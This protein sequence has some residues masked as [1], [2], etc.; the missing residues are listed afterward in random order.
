MNPTHPNFDLPLPRR[1]WWPWNEGAGWVGFCQTFNNHHSVSAQ[2]YISASGYYRA[3]LDHDEIKPAA[4]SMPSWRSMHNMQVFLT[5][6][7]HLLR[8][9]AHTGGNSQPFLMVCL[10]WEEN[11]QHFRVASGPQW[12][13]TREPG[14]GWH[15]GQD[16]NNW[17][18]AWA[19]DGPWAEPWGMPCNAP[20]DFCRLS[21]GWQQVEDQRLTCVAGLFSGLTTAGGAARLLVGGAIALRPSWPHAL[22]IPA[23]EHTRPRLEW[24]RTRE[25]HS[26]ILNTWL[27]LFEPRAPHVVFDCGQETFARLRV[28]VRSGG[29]TILAITT[30]ESLNEVHRYA[31][32][33]TDIFELKDGQSYT[34]APTGFR[35][36]KI[37]A[38]SAAKTGDEVMIEP[39]TAEHIRYPLTRRGSFQ[40]SDSLLNKVWDL[41][42]L[43]TH[44]CMQNE[45]WDGIK[46]DQLPWM[47]DLYTEALAIYT[48]FGDYQLTRHTLSVLAEIGP[49]EARPLE[50]QLYP[51]LAAI[52]KSGMSS[53]PGADSGDING[54][55]SYTLWWI[56]GLADYV[57]FSGDKSLIQQIGDELEQTL[58]H[59]HS[60]IGLNHV[61]QFHGGWDFID[62]AP[63][64]QEERA[65]YCH[66]LA[67][68]AL[69]KGA[70]LLEMIGKPF[71]EFQRTYE[72]MEQATRSLWP[73]ARGFGLSHHVN[74]MVIRSGIFTPEQNAGLFHETLASDPALSMTYWHRY[75]DLEAAAQVNQIQW[76]LDYIRKH[77][78]LSLQL[79][80]S[81][82]WEA[83]DPS[84]IGPDPHAVSMVG[85]EYARYGGY[86]TSL[87]H[88][89]SAGP[90]VWFHQAVL[91]ILPASPGFARVDFKPNLGDLDWAR[92][93]V[94]TPTGKII[95]SLARGKQTK[96]QA[97]LVVPPEIEIRFADKLEDSWQIEIQQEKP[98]HRPS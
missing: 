66:L 14:P 87:C 59:I 34:T 31:R 12:M 10:D 78:G 95:V 72:G 41:S 27:D 40:C 80:L 30:G 5:P 77:W 33:V 90:A 55:P 32:R 20:V 45:V 36:V 53:H 63:V 91:G 81:T 65:I 17:R 42:A 49:A 4:A 2:L 75:L 35:F 98:W 89:W 47:G 97:K 8:L 25:A 94:L 57:L 61:W 76:G 79:G 6:G 67:Y 84:W 37:M 58:A 69:K 74:A 68:L 19:F 82:L 26:L 88:G 43:T 16:Q 28:Q 71:K 93:E 52:W 85:A 23:I 64:I 60:W 46:R 54:I 18:Q 24:Y 83:F 9:E 11:N 51:G 15:N 48:L 13:M 50:S 62:W 70:A 7:N 1:M 3:W 44:L 73:E 96:S 56:I 86:E 29:P 21:T 92:G 22:H 39:I 38:L